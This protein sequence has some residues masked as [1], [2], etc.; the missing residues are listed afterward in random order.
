[1]NKFLKFLSILIMIIAGLGIILN[2]AIAILAWTYNTPITDALL[3]PLTSIRDTDRRLVQVVDQAQS[4]TGEAANAI[5]PVSEQ[6]EKIQTYIET[7][8]PVLDLVEQF[9]GR[10]LEQ[11]LDGLY[12]TLLSLNESAAALNSSAQLMNALPFVDI[13]KVV[14]GTQELEDLLNNLILGIDDF[15]SQVAAVK[16]EASQR[17]V[18]PVIDTLDKIENIIL[19]VQARLVEFRDQLVAIDQALSGLIDSLPAIIDWI[20]LVITI[21][22]LW[23]ILAQAALIYL[24]VIYYKY[25]Q[26]SFKPNTLEP[27]PQ[28]ESSSLQ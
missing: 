26:L 27:T 21:V 3:A 6:I 9:S 4:L 14:Q 24:A 17:F 19:N 2:A 5:S 22:M 18:Q 13:P 25:G 23:M 20:S 16:V 11:K 12:A 7:G 28:P 1:M 10:D 8:Q 15:R